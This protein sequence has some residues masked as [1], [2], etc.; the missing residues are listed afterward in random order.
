MTKLFEIP[1]YAC[2]P[3]VLSKRVKKYKEP[4]L[5]LAK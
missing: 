3:T 4:L 1:I 2:S 5:S